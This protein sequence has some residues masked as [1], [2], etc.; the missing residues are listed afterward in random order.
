MRL[1]VNT[2]YAIRMLC[3]LAQADRPVSLAALAERIGTSKRALENVH[4]LLKRHGITEGSVGPRGGL[5]MKRALS[6]IRVGEL[7]LLFDDAVD[8]SMCRTGR[9]AC[10]P[11][12]QQ[13]P[14]R[15]NWR[16][17][18]SRLQDMLNAVTLKEIMQW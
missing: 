3:T 12:G 11:E 4:A 6:D 1:S 14:S 16:A 18:S 15:V 5:T 13:C 8:L 9:S 7:L 10:C 17:V 2:R